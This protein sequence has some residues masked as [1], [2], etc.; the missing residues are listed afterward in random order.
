M[1]SGSGMVRHYTNCIYFVP[2]VGIGVRSGRLVSLGVLHVL[3]GSGAFWIRIWF[4]I[5][6]GVVIGA[7]LC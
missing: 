1:A 7:G 6:D 5:S 3:G 4:A 2:F